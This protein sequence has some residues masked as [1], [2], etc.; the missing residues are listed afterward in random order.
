MQPSHFVVNWCHRKER[1][2]GEAGNLISG[3]LL[4]QAFCPSS[5]AFPLPFSG[6]R[7][8]GRDSAVGT[9][10]TVVW[11]AGA[12]TRKE[13]QIIWSLETSGGQGSLCYTDPWVWCGR[14]HAPYIALCSWG[15]G[16]HQN[17]LNPVVNSSG[18]RKPLPSASRASNTCSS[19]SRLSGNSSWSL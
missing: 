12:D 14:R 19:S 7:G 13:A 18:V 17:L 9:E 1:R 4:R 6:G 10:R 3:P 11:T 16:I 2:Q 8:P 15:P 5:L